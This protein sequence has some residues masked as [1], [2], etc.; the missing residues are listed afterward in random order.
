MARKDRSRNS[1]RRAS[2]SRGCAPSAT[3]LSG[4]RPTWSPCSM[5]AWR[6][7]AATM[8]AVMHRE[9]GVG[10][11]APQIG[12]LSRI[13][14]WRHPEND[15]EEYVFVNPQ[16]VSRSEE[17]TTEGEGCLS[18]PGCTVEVA[19][20][21]EVVVDRPGPARAT[22][23][24]LEAS[25]LVARIMQHEIDH[26]DGRLILDRAT[27]EERRRVL[28]ELRERTLARRAREVRLRRSPDFAAW[29]SPSD[30]VRARAAVRAWSSPSPTARWAGDGGRPRLRRR[31]SPGASAWISSSR[32]TS[33]PPK[34]SDALR[35]AGVEVLVVAAFGQ[36]LRRHSARSHPVHQRP[37]VAAARL[38][39]SGAH[40]AC[41][42]GGGDL[43]RASA[44]CGYVQALDSGPWAL[45]TSLSIEP[46]GTTPAP[47]AA[48]WRS[49]AP[50][51]ST[52]C[53]TGLEDGTVVWTEQEGAVPSMRRSC[54]A[55]DC[56]LDIGRP[57]R[58]GARPGAVAQ[59]AG[60]GTGG[61]RRLRVQGVAHL[62]L[63]AALGSRRS[64]RRRRPSP[65]GRAR[66]Q[67][68]DDRLF[69]GL[70]R[71]RRGDAQRPAGR[72]EQD[73]RRR[74]PARV[75][76]PL[77]PDDDR[78]AGGLRAGR[79]GRVESERGERACPSRQPHTGNCI[80]C[81]PS[82]R[83]ISPA[84]AKRSPGSWTPGVRIIHCD[85]MDGHF[86]PNLTIG[87][88]VVAAH[89]SRWS[90]RGADC[91]RST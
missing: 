32:P 76:R 8:L 27:P 45:Q 69:V 60:G 83:P 63:R 81:R 84:W 65:A 3:R 68:L 51:A 59:P 18:V 64:R 57:A 52:R 39:G 91:S 70:R 16:I 7:S 14:V 79:A 34:S 50:G 10:L 19:R 53:S 12:V 87:P 25:G 88:A 56:L 54:A 43:H 82:S 72:Q 26:L 49:W 89:R 58:G 86:V 13:M 38:P 47:S 73:D 24:E 22:P 48:P 78:A 61:E 21:D 62:A 77:G 20:A 41:A 9:E 75:P 1:A 33:T 36:I 80:C 37:R 11:A 66:W 28:K 2:R 31:S 67:L 23:F 71:G 74:V 17:C 6:S 4:S 30:L 40:R 35:A 85:V 42:G 55:E 90:T 15:D 5:P 29:T 46:A 44:S